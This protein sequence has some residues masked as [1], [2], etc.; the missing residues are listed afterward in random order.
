MPVFAMKQNYRRAPPVLAWAKKVRFWFTIGG[1]FFPNLRIVVV[2]HDLRLER[3]CHRRFTD[4][5]G[6]FWKK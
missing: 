4:Q 3:S 5:I 6:V 1:A 2:F